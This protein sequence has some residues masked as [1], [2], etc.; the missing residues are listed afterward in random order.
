MLRRLQNF[1]GKNIDAQNTA[2]VAMVRG[3]LVQKNYVDKSAILPVAATD[4]YFVTK[5]VQPTGL[6][7]YEGDVSEYD[8]RLDNIAS[9]E[10]V[11]L[12]KP[13]SGERYATDQFV[14]AGLVDGGFATVSIV[15]GAT[16]GKVITSAIASAFI[17]NGTIAENGHTLAIIE[18]L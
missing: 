4:L 7:S 6:M 17:Y 13:I 8:T 14:A 1:N 15:V 18:V 10:A 16:Q 3:M 9:G 12:E 11:Q 2:G 5:D